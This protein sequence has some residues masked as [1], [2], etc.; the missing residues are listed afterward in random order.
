MALR[1][2]GWKETPG[3]WE[4]QHKWTLLAIITLL[5][6]AVGRLFLSGMGPN[7]HIFLLWTFGPIAFRSH[8]SWLCLQSITS[9][10]L[11]FC[12]RC[13]WV[14]RYGQLWAGM[15]WTSVRP[16]F[17]ISLP[18]MTRT[19]FYGFCM[20]VFPVVFCCGLGSL[21]LRK[22]V[23]NLTLGTPYVCVISHPVSKCKKFDWIVPEDARNGYKNWTTIPKRM[24]D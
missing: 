14:D 7:P 21:G 9:F 8:F 2:V 1:I 22:T 12:K 18:R 3:P 5:V 16:L 17:W 15:K 11:P 19:S 13:E 6:V 23:L 24:H 10:P 4:S 20:H